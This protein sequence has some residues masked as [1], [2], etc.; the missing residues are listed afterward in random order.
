[1]VMM[2]A[3]SDP[4][5]VVHVLRKV[6]SILEDEPALV[7]LIQAETRLEIWQAVCDHIRSIVDTI[8]TSSSSEFHH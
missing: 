3:I 1:V 7:K 2:L 6:I 8:S 4:D 5:S